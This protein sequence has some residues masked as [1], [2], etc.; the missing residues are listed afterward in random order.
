M[1][2]ADAPLRTIPARRIVVVVAPANG[3]FLSFPKEHTPHFTKASKYW[4]WRLPRSIIKLT[5]NYLIGGES[6]TLAGNSSPPLKAGTI[7]DLEAPFDVRTY[8]E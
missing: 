7:D 5:L 4:C 2:G 8:Y 3:S 1:A 6:K